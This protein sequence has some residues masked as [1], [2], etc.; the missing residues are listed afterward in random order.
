MLFILKSLF[1]PFPR[2]YLASG[3]SLMY[4]NSHELKPRPPFQA[5]GCG[6]LVCAPEFGK[7]LSHQPNEP[8]TDVRWT[9]SAPQT[10]V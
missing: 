1:G 4:Q 9:R 3:A 5:V 10:L 2:S 8:S 7:Q 6:S